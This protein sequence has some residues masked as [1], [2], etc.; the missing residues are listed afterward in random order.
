MGEEAE[1]AQPVIDGDH[2]DIVRHQRAGIVAVA[3]TDDQPSTV[4]PEHHGQEM[5]PSLVR[6]PRSEDVQKQTVLCRARYSVGAGD[7]RTVRPERRR[8]QNAC[9]ACKLLRGAPTKVSD[10]WFG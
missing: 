9:P 10:R 3:L 8:V 7:L 5:R 4:N 2:D 6:L 1:P